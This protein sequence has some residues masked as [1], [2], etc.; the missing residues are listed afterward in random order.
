MTSSA[1]RLRVLFYIATLDAGGAER[2][3]LELLRHLDRARFDPIL[4]L[5]TRQGP[6]LADVPPDVP[7]HA[8]QETP[9][10]PRRFGLGRLARWRFLSNLLRQKRIDVVYDRTL[11]ATL[12]T[13]PATWWRNTP[14]ISAVVADPR[15]QMDLYFPRRQWLWRRFAQRVYRSASIVLANSQGLRRQVI[16]YFDL[17]PDHVRLLPNVLD[18]SRLDRLAIDATEA[19]SGKRKLEDEQTLSGL[20]PSNQFRILTV[21]RIDEHKGHRDLLEA[22]RIL[23]HDQGR[24]QLL[25]QIIGDGPTRVPLLAEIQRLNLGS[26]VEWLG[27]MTNPYPHYRAVNLFCLP[28]LTEGSPNVLLE[29]LALGTPVVSTDCPS[30]PREILED[31]RWGTLV[32]M[33]D[34]AAMAEVIAA[35]MDHPND[36]MD[37]AAHA[38]SVIRERYDVA[39]GVRKL[40]NLLIEAAGQGS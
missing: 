21:G 29:A 6:L 34:P 17:P 14:R 13:G 23:V 27:V 5:T 40:E 7:I 15:I 25:W 1:S 37:R 8:F 16:D 18:A 3:L 31:G 32:P 39:P 22:V 19:D 36:G 12:D 4:G 9:S 26:H 11:Q 28:S 24:S 35:R 33:Q 38:K 20:R 30:G 2:Q 10:G